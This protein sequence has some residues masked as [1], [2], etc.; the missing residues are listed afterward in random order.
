MDHHNPIPRAEGRPRGSPQ[1]RAPTPG[2]STRH[3]PGGRTRP[4]G[5]EAPQVQR[6]PPLPQ[7]P[8]P[9]APTPGPRPGPR[10]Q[11]TA[12]QE[13]AR[14]R[15]KTKSD[16]ERLAE[17]HLSALSSSDFPMICGAVL[18]PGRRCIIDALIGNLKEQPG[19]VACWSPLTSIV[20]ICPPLHQSSSVLD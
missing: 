18:Y 1:Q 14:T 2:N 5:R 17:A 3:S 4:S 9:R 15:R 10:V 8:C 19:A 7:G 6:P 20:Y 11:T 16:E 12:P 13:S